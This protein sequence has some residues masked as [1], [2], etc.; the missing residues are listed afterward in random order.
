MALTLYLLVMRLVTRLLDVGE[1]PGMGGTGTPEP[2]DGVGVEGPFTEMADAALDMG[3]VRE[4][5]GAEDGPGV[6]GA[7]IVSAAIWERTAGGGGV[8]RRRR[9]W[10]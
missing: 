3:E 5:D 4:P 6:P 9:G 7:D 8:A 2:V 1:M 10:W